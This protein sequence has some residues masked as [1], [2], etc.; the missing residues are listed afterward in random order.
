M[1]WEVPPL[2]S[3]MQPL[4]HVY[5][6]PTFAPGINIK[7]FGWWL[8]KKLYRIGHYLTPMRQLS[9]SYC[10]S[11]LEMPDSER[12]QFMKISHFLNSQWKNR[13]D[14]PKLTAYEHWCGQTTEQRG[15]I[16][17]IYLSLA[18]DN[19]KLPYM[20]AWECEIQESWT[21][22][23]WHRNFFHSYKGINNTI[24][25]EANLKVLT[26]WYLVPT[27][28]AKMFPSSSPFCFRGCNSPVSMI[29]IW[30]ECLRLQGFWIIIFHIICKV[31]SSQ[32]PKD[33]TIALLNAQI[34]DTNRAIQD[35]IFYILLGAKLTIARAC[36]TKGF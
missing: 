11:K 19:A 28:L 33:L 10:K 8:D 20:H 30:W 2:T 22:D 26:R 1:A 6:S 13:P 36:T 15:V 29:H 27:R 4:V 35:L 17:T 9:L 14:P 24:L 21:A 32:I 23:I 12:F 34:P 16:S 5:H 31:I 25:I 3:D 18:S 7:T